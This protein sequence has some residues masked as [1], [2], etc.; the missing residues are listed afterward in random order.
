[1]ELRL[2]AALGMMLIIPGAAF[3]SCIGLNQ[4]YRG[5]QRIV[6]IIGISVAF[7]PL[8][9]YFLDILPFQFSLGPYKI[10]IILFLC[11]GI[12]AVNHQQHLRFLFRL[13]FWEWIA[14]LVIAVTLF[15]RLWV[16]YQLPYPAW[17]D[18]VH[19]VMITKL[20][21][22]T[23]RLP[24]NLEPYFPIPLD[25]YHLG[26]HTIAAT[27]AWLAQ[28]S[29][30]S[31]L[32]WTAQILNGL[33]GIGVYLALDRKVGRFAAV[34]GLAVVGVFSYQPAF[35][36][37]WGRFTQIASQAILLIAWIATD[38]AIHYW[39]MIS[40]STWLRKT[41]IAKSL[42]CSILIAGMLL[43]HFRVA[44]FFIL[45]IIPCAITIFWDFR[46]NKSSLISALTGSSVIGLFVLLMIA[47]AFFSAIAAFVKHATGALPKIINQ[48]QIQQSHTTYYDAP[49]TS[50]LALTAQ[51][52]LLVITAL[53]MLIGIVVRNRMILLNTLWI[54]SLCGLGNLY[55]LGIRPL[56]IV[57]LSGTVIMFYLPI[58]LIIGSCAQLILELFRERLRANIQSLVVGLVLLLSIPAAKQRITQIEMYR[59][60]VT[61]ADI[62]AMSWIRKNIPV[63]ARFA[64]NTYFWLPT[65]AYGTDAGYWIPYFTERKTT[66]GGMLMNLASE[67][68]QT[69]MLTMSR[70]VVQLS[71]DNSTLPTLLASG[72]QYI[73]IGK[74][75]DPSGAV[76]D[77]NRLK[78]AP[79]I[80]V[81][82]ESDGVT[83]LEILD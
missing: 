29:F 28:T 6:I 65:N 82:Y 47:P 32:L 33:C 12:L 11:L 55:R 64:I 38:D 22:T 73:Y 61:N 27:S 68:Y 34:I 9:F 14:V 37:N 25:M 35:Y 60:F 58:G 45:L 76:L 3:L 17:T 40:E 75:G 57:N 2:L 50:I 70:M 18:S 20:I 52:W 51:S 16:A 74:N 80:K 69:E 41:A 48:E 8:L 1:M 67:A 44:A 39:G 24:E 72:V 36:V 10:A 78:L 15:T 63:D 23:G 66:T 79:N 4:T 49:I 13:D 46:H 77:P 5:L 43:I 56:N 54:L 83:I 71:K 30:A 42:L 26:L 31:A 81:I 53:A 59:F 19:H 62:A 21:A 7:Y